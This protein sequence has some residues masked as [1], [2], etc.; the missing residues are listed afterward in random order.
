MGSRYS[1]FQNFQGDGI[2]TSWFWLRRFG[3]LAL[4]VFA[5]AAAAASSLG[6]PPQPASS[7]QP[8]KS[9]GIPSQEPARKPKAVLHPE[10]LAAIAPALQRFVEQGEIAGAV[11]VVG[12]S[13]GIIHHEAVGWRDR[14]ARAPMPK[15]ALFRIASMTKPITAVAVMILVDEGKLHPDDDVAKYL[16]EFSRSMVLVEQSPQR[17]VLRPPQRPIKVRD[18]LTH[19]AGLAPYPPGV[20]DVYVRRNRTLAETTLAAALSPL[21]FD[22]G[23]RWSYSN[24]G[25]DTLGRLIE[26][27]SGQRYEEFLR[28]R[29][30]LPLGMYDTTFAPSGEQMRRLAVTYGLDKNGRLMPNPNTLIALVPQPRHPVPAGGL[31]SSGTDLARFYR[32]MLRQGELDGTRILSPK[33]VAEMTRLQTG[34]LKT[35]F[36]EG[37][38]FGYG[39]AVVRQPQGVTAM[40]SPGS[41]GHGGAFGTQGWIDPQRDLFIILLIQ[42]TGLP[43][44]DASP[45][46]QVLQELAVAAVSP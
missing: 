21:Q 40:L 15:D 12:R 30:F 22:P 11:T 42:R 27:V 23:T 3:R 1:N 37:M 10:K 31:V 45:M 20:N 24:P 34:E 6:Q 35:G 13:G 18:L 25:I 19:T 5:V 46:R 17:V 28:Q 4:L 32:M 44:A 7:E 41:Y 39:W 43:N 8:P 33:A 2:M 36:V 9:G 16:P 29:I 14:E 26:V 38:G